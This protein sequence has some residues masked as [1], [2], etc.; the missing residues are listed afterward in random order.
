MSLH[1]A[2][3]VEL[4]RF[5]QNI[6]ESDYEIHLILEKPS[7]MIKTIMKI[8]EECLLPFLHKAS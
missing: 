8:Y 1:L 4:E 5:L 7:L 2:S 3:F 6:C